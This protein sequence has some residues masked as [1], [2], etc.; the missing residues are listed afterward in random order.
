MDLGLR[1]VAH[2][3]GVFLLV[4]LVKFTTFLFSS[5][6]EEVGQLYVIDFSYGEG[7]VLDKLNCL[8]LYGLGGWIFF[9]CL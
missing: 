4:V 9:I 6:K 3:C 1:C 8:W 2:Q 7:N 5:L